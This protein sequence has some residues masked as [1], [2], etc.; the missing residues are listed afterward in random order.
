M[1]ESP[2]PADRDAAAQQRQQFRFSFRLLGAELL[3]S[4]TPIPPGIE[5]RDWFA[6][7]ALMGYIQYVS[8]DSGGLLMD[9]VAE[10]SY[11]MADAMLRAKHRQVEKPPPV[12]DKLAGE[13]DQRPGIQ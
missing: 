10:T 5:L 3:W 1:P 6:S 11:R 4:R 7:M 9:R 13:S 2:A 8:Q 12:A